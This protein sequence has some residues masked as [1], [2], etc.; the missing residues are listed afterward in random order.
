MKEMQEPEVNMVTNQV[1]L[2][3]DKTLSGVMS[4]IM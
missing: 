3:I 4:G 2:R 1:M